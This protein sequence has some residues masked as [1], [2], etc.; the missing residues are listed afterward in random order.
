MK[1]IFFLLLI[2]LFV[3]CQ[4]D[5]IDRHDGDGTQINIY[6]VKDGQIERDQTQ[7][8]LKKLVLESHPWLK[9]SEIEFYDWS[10]HIFYLNTEKKKAEHAGK[11]FVLK[12]DNRPL[13]LGYF[14][15]IFSS[16]IPKFPSVIAHDDFFYPSDVIGL[17]GY[18]FLARD[19]ASLNLSAFKMELGNAGLL[20]NGIEVDLLE[21]TR[22]NSS[23]L[24]YKFKVTNLDNENIYI[25]DPDK[26]G[27]AR[28]HYYTNGVYLQQGNDR[29]SPHDFD[30]LASDKIDNSWYFK[31]ASGNSITRTVEQNG[32]PHLPT[33]EVKASFNFPGMDLKNRG[34]WKK[35]DGRIWMGDFW[36]EKELVV[37]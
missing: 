23:T 35:R 7:V 15:P 19:S 34:Q 1:N 27:A 10:A 11:Y 3:S 2:F 21:L 29:F 6:L 9:H 28:F 17:G 4:K 30:V 14:F 25:P 37:K 13:F 32:Y 24:K 5:E 12:A 33:G 16:M 31:L 26:M 8:D 18:G 20:R 22:E 36:V